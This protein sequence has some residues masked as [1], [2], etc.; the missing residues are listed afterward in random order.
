[1]R[2]NFYFTQASLESYLFIFLTFANLT[3]RQPFFT[4][5]LV[6][7]SLITNWGSVFLKLMLYTKTITCFALFIENIFPK[8][9]I[10]RKY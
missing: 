7:I 10:I 4:V 5:A 6:S 3:G 9:E 2:E 8:G 1:M